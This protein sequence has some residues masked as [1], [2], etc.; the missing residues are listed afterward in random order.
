MLRLRPPPQSEPKPKGLLWVYVGAILGALVGAKLSFLLAEG[1]FYRHDTIAL[2]S[3]K[4][5]TGSLLGGYLGVEVAKSHIN[6][7]SPTGDYFAVVVPLGLAIGRIGCLTQGCCLGVECSPAW[8]TLTDAQ[9]HAR[10]PAAGVE[11][12]FNLLFAVVAARCFA[13]RALLGNLF[14]LYLI[15]YGLFRF[16][17]EFARDDSRWWGPL[18]GYHLVAAAL[19]VLGALRWRT[20]DQTTV[21]QAKPTGE[22]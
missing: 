2:L 6:Y 12:L 11:L 8:Y 10:W 14:H 5:V 20:V 18:G 16:T 3:G 9:S 17:H 21:L 22:S 19:V 1:W 13:R 7:R 4:S 15:A